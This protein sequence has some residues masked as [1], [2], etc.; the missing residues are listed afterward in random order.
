[1][2]FNIRKITNHAPS[3]VGNKEHM[4]ECSPKRLHMGTEQQ[5]WNKT[6]KWLKS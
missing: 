4:H 3:P 5:D 6:N 1:M 2:D